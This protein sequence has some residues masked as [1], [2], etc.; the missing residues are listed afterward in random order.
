[1]RLLTIRLIAV[2]VGVG[3][4]GLSFWGGA[5]YQNG[6]D[7]NLFTAYNPPQSQGAGGRGAGLG[8]GGG[9]TNGLVGAA[10][11]VGNP[12]SSSATGVSS[13]AGNGGTG[14]PAS[15]TSQPTPVAG[16]GTTAA[17]GQTTAL[18]GTLV[19][20]AKTTLSLKT[21]DNKTDSLQI[22][23]GTLF[24][25][26]SKASTSALAVGQ[27]VT[28]SGSRD[29]QQQ[30]VAASVTIA[31]SGSLYGSVRPLSQL[32]QA[33][34]G[35]AGTGSG[36]GT[37]GF[38][39]GQGGAAQGG[40][41]GFGGGQTGG[42]SSGNGFGGGQSGAGAQGGGNGFGGAPAGGGQGGTT[43]GGGSVGSGQARRG[44]GSMYGTIASVSAGSISIQT[45]QGFSLDVTTNASTL[46]YQIAPIAE[47]AVHS[48]TVVTIR[49]ASSSGQQV[50]ESVVATTLPNTG[51]LL[52]TPRVRSFSGGGFGAGCRWRV[53]R[54]PRSRGRRLGFGELIPTRR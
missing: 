48:G 29:S 34:A 14:S 31:P 47:S 54:L 39:G 17:G 5:L 41:N 21:L 4:M 10:L 6:Q 12:P 52:T 15:N 40:G 18:A 9:G 2:P 3:L 20:L 30:F 37:G 35:A 53:Q 7:Q 42:Q 22:A 27:R 38:G 45:L 23:N 51:A 32:Q 25:E 28:I 16:G 13:T 8:G 26:A 33:I 46:V 19:S 43:Q 1:M 49:A 24:Y 44:G 36:A 11:S 50:A